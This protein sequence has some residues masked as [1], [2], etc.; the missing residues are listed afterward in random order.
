MIKVLFGNYLEMFAVS[1]GNEVKQFVLESGMRDQL[2]MY[3][4]SS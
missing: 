4:Q 2:V 3:L 1:Y